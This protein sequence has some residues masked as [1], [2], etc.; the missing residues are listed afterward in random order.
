MNSI[1]NFNSSV[2]FSDLINLTKPIKHTICDN[3]YEKI[4]TIKNHNYILYKN[5]S[6]DNYYID[7][8][9]DVTT[10]KYFIKI[11][12]NISKKSF[13]NI[14]T[15]YTTKPTIPRIGTMHFIP[16]N[17]MKNEYEK[18][19][20]SPKKFKKNMFGGLILATNESFSILIDSIINSDLP[21]EKYYVFKNNVKNKFNFLSI[22]TYFTQ[23][24]IE[25]KHH[26]NLAFSDKDKILC[27]LSV[28][29][30]YNINDIN[31]DNN[32]YPMDVKKIMDIYTLYDIDEFIKT[33]NIT[34][35]M[36]INELKCNEFI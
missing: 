23:S 3:V 26:A 25:F 4:G 22:S 24:I 12:N 35:E 8:F 5:I 18:N 30:Y 6:N 20:L 16:L 13:V 21:V 10:D 36:I 34:S 2:N 19:Y 29:F 28:S 14:I 11:E 32:Y 33:F 9:N 1:V 7:I 31:V 27:P 15:Y 17:K